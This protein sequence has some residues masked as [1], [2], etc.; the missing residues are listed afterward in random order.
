MVDQASELDFHIN[1]LH[2]HHSCHGVHSTGRT[3]STRV[4]FCC[5]NDSNFR[6]TEKGGYSASIDESGADN[7]EGIKNTSFNH[8]D[9]LASGAVESLVEVAAELIGELANNNRAFSS[10]VLDN[11]AGGVCDGVL[12]NGDTELLVEVGSLDVLKS[13]DRGLKKTSTTTGEDTLLDGGASGVQSI[14]DAVLL[15]ANLDFGG[16]ADL[17][18]GDT[19]GKLSKTLLELLLLVLG[20]A[21]VS[22]DTA[23]LL[24]ALRDRVLAAVTVEEDSVLLGNGDSSGGA[25]HVGGSLL[26]L[27]VKVVAED[28]TVGQDSEIAEDRLAVVTEAGSLNGSDLELATKLVEDA[29]SKSLAIDILSNDEEG[30]ALLLG[31]LKSGNDVLNS[32][33]LLLGEEDQRLLEFNLGAL[34]I[35][36]EVGGD[37]A[38]VEL[39]SLGDLELILNGLALLHGDDTLLADLLHGVGEELANVSVTVGGDGGDLGDFLAGGDLLLVCA[40][41]LDNSLDG[42]L[43]SAPQVH[44]VASSGDVLD[45][46]GEDSAG[47]NGGGCGT[48]TSN[49]VGLGGDVLEKTSTKVLELVLKGNGLGDGYTIW[50]MSVAGRTCLF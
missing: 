36:D 34:G 2:T 23:D 18:D 12:D 37:V 16:T 6:C 17:N 47:E 35:G 39:H 26:E 43:G 1:P 32:R 7:L 24:A 29:D 48:V 31:S 45:G 13:V 8:V 50:D 27:D 30:T 19:A 4:L 44:R 28:S 14:D 5:L 33:D 40:Q 3:S 42:G 20:S 46:L 10:G 38:A 25:E 21:G 9:V 11:L 49:L 41:V 22:H 15:L